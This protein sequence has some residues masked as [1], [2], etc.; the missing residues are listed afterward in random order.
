VTYR[1]NDHLQLLKPFQRA[2]V[3]YVFQ[4]LFTDAAPTRRYHGSVPAVSKKRR[5]GLRRPVARRL[6]ALGGVWTRSP[7]EPKVPVQKQRMM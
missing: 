6:P 2:T 5:K 7:R 4:R 3:D 1:A